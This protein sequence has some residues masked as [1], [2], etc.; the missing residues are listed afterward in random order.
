M[1]DSLDVV[2]SRQSLDVSMLKDRLA[3][4]QKNRRQTTAVQ[5]KINASSHHT[6]VCVAAI[7][8]NRIKQLLLLFNSK[9]YRYFDL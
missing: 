8:L 7:H 9:T 5:R 2:A 1:V 6:Q 3:V 4:R